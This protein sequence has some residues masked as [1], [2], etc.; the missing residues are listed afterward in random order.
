MKKGRAALLWIGIATISGTL[1][2]LISC[3]AA[4]GPSTEDTAPYQPH[5]YVAGSTRENGYDHACYWKDDVR[6]DL[7][8]TSFSN[9]YGIAVTNGTVYIVGYYD[10]K[11]CL[12]INGVRQNLDGGNSATGIALSDN[13]VVIS[14]TTS[15]LIPKACV[16]VNGVQ[17]V[18]ETGDSCGNAVAVYNGTIYLAGSFMDQYD[19]YKA[20]VWTKPLSGGT[21]TEQV[22]HV[23]TIESTTYESSEALAITVQNGTILV[24]GYQGDTVGNYYAFLWS[25][26]ST[27]SLAG[28]ELPMPNAITATD[29]YGH[30]FGIALENDQQYIAG[31]YNV[32]IDDSSYASRAALWRGTSDPDLYAPGD[33]SDAAAFS[34]VI[35]NGD[36]YVAGNI[37]KP[38]S[39]NSSVYV[40][41]CYWKNGIRMELSAPIAASTNA[42][43]Y[44]DIGA[45]AIVVK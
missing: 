15:D 33:E 39:D 34:V 44:W 14:G 32:K 20:A 29:P 38:T 22:I 8:S 17:A 42:E 2:L 18:V 1:S 16:W 43:S 4:A 30:A 45:H 40:Q 36:V 31:F 37:E 28:T 7:E 5:V 23:N 35:Y 10:N 12:W 41:P 26:T 27:A 6:I 25:G 3:M 19:N 21:W 9:A 11:A 13:T 24:G